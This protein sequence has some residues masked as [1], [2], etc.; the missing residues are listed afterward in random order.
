MSVA[1]RAALGLGAACALVDPGSGRF[2]EGRAQRIPS[3][4]VR[5][6]AQ[7]AVDVERV[8]EGSSHL[9]PLRLTERI[10]RQ[11]IKFLSRIVALALAFAGSRV[12]RPIALQDRR[13]SAHPPLSCCAWPPYA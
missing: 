6:P 7:R 13:C 10:F 1:T 4:H 3:G 9:L 11:P 2:E 8:T 5:T 12:G